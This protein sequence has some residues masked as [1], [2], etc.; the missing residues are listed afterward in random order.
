VLDVVHG[1]CQ[2]HADMLVV[3]PIDG[4]AP[5]PL[6]D[7]EPEMTEQAQMMGNGRLLHRHCIR[8]FVD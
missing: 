8:K 3:E 7:D 1:L 4:A 2:E 6:A 5:V